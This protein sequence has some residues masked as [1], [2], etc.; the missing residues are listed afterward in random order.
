MGIE[1]KITPVKKDRLIFPVF[2]ESHC[3]L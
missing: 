2:E 3:K 1:T